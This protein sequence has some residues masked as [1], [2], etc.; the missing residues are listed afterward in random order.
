M[1]VFR[2]FYEKFH[3]QR[4]FCS[5]EN[6]HCCDGGSR[7]VKMVSYCLIVLGALVTGPGILMASSG[8]AGNLNPTYAG[9]GFL[10]FGGLMVAT[11]V[12][13]CCTH[14]L[15]KSHD[16]EHTSVTTSQP[17]FCVVSENPEGLE[18]YIQRR[19][20]PHSESMPI[21]ATQPPGTQGVIRCYVLPTS[22]SWPNA[23]L[24]RAAG[25]V[26]YYV[27]RPLTPH[28]HSSSSSNI[29]T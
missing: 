7:A 3:I 2:T 6:G 14:R 9:V 13:L 22:I 18:D 15:R 12:M 8:H 1:S 17:A 20:L 10:S 29:T 28:R 21:S 24:N 25:S 5:R 16:T 27:G 26:V 23:N 11:G 19:G 4:C